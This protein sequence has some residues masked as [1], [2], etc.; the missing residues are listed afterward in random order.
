MV[1]NSVDPLCGESVEKTLRRDADRNPALITHAN[2][3]VGAMPAVYGFLHGSQGG[4]R[5]RRR[6]RGAFQPLRH[7]R[8]RLRMRP[9]PVSPRNLSLGGTL[10]RHLIIGDSIMKIVTFGLLAAAALALGAC[11]NTTQQRIGG[12]AVGAGTGAVVAGPVGAVVGGAA[13]A[14]TAPGVVRGTRR[15]TR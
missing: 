12:A 7:S 9:A 14:I 2:G 5:V 13:G 11:G 6:S 15:A 8:R 4:G 10:T 3:A 1:V